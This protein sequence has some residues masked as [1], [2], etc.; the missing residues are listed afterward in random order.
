MMGSSFGEHD[1]I[2]EAKVSVHMCC[3]NEI[4]GTSQ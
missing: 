2:Q 4:P 1:G 3:C